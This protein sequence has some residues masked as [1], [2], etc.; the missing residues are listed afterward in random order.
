L[1]PEKPLNHRRAQRK[2]ET[3]VADLFAEP[4]IRALENEA[5]LDVREPI[6]RAA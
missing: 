1:R 3:K 6:S 4:W 5:A 2:V